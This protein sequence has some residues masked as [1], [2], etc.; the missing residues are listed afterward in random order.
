[1]PR[2]VCVQYSLRLEACELY[3]IDSHTE[4]QMLLN[5]WR[6]STVTRQRFC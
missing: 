3:I 2:A 1:M 5:R 4:C 6:Q